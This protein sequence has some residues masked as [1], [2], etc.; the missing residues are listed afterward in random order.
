[1]EVLGLSLFVFSA[2][3]HVLGPL[4][5][6]KGGQAFVDGRDVWRW[7]ALILHQL[8]VGDSWSTWPWVTVGDG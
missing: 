5:G 6:Q 2:F 8:A 1:M 7:G 3:S 4:D